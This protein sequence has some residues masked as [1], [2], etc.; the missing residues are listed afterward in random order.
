[1]TLPTEPILR[2]ASS[3]S[4]AQVMGLISVWPNTAQFRASGKV[5]AMARRIV[6]VDGA[7]PQE[8]LRSTRLRGRAFCSAQTA[9]HCTGTRKMLVICSASRV[10]R[11]AAGSKACSGWTTV[12]PPSWRLGAIEPSAAMWNIGAAHSARPSSSNSRNTRMQVRDCAV[13][14]S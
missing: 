2:I 14:F 6:S 9:C 4:R 5:S 10:S 3:P 11:T 7:A 13:R 8:M 1:M 12:T